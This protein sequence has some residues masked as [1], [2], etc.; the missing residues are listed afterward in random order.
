LLGALASGVPLQSQTTTFT[1]TWYEEV[2]GENI[3]QGAGTLMPGTSFELLVLPVMASR[4]D[5]DA[6]LLVFGT[7]RIS[8]LNEDRWVHKYTY[9]RPGAATSSVG[10]TSYDSRWN[11]PLVW[12]NGVPN[13]NTD[14]Q[15]LGSHI[16]DIPNN[17]APRTSIVLPPSSAGAAS[18]R[19]L[20][21]YAT[22]KDSEGHPLVQEVTL[23]GGT[24][25][26]TPLAF[27][28]SLRVGVASA[29]VGENRT[30]ELTLDGTILTSSGF[31]AIG[32]GLPTGSGGDLKAVM[33]LG[34]NSAWYHHTGLIEV[35]G[36][37][38]TG[39]LLIDSIL[40]GD[41][42]SG[43][44]SNPNLVINPQGKVSTSGTVRLNEVSI[45]SHFPAAD[46]DSAPYPSLTVTEWGTFDTQAFKL[47]DATK[48]AASVLGLASLG[49][50]TV[51]NGSILSLQTANAIVADSL[52]LNS[53]TVGVYAYDVPVNPFII[54]RQ[55]SN[56]GS[57][58]LTIAG[59]KHSAATLQLGG[60]AVLP[61]F[62]D[63]GY[64]GQVIVHGS[65]LLGGYGTAIVEIILASL[66][67]IRG[68]ATVG[69]ISTYRESDANGSGL[70][71]VTGGSKLRAQ[72]IAIGHEQDSFRSI[73][74]TV[75]RIDVGSSG[76]IEVAG[77][78]VSGNAY[79][80]FT[81]TLGPVSYNYGGS[82]TVGRYGLLDLLNGT[83]KVV[84]TDPSA[85]GFLHTPAWLINHGTITGGD[86]TGGAPPAGGQ[87]DFGDR[88]G[89]L[90]NYG[91]IAPG[92]SAGW[93]TIT[94]NLTL[95][96]TS[97]L[98]LELGGTTRGSGYDALTVTGELSAG[99]TLIVS[100][101]NG[102][103]PTSG[104]SFDLFDFGSTSGTFATVNLP[105]GYAWNTDAL[106]TTGVISL[107]AVP[108]PSTYALCAGL[109]ALGIA[110]VRR[111]LR[112]PRCIPLRRCVGPVVR[113][114]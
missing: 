50:I 34:N 31:A 14:A 66:L 5:W 3:Q 27:S 90:S 77:W 16:G 114:I 33:T 52:D 56:P 68:D 104:A 45:N 17:R 38:G 82:L 72:N 87:I 15:I 35:G 44:G 76:R 47:G 83:G 39:R 105:V 73:E 103:S 11:N 12:G 109:G 112:R 80:P 19:S 92:H 24:L 102:F 81:G 48:G 37:T 69:R 91:T 13:A 8:P 10:Y 95:E 6:Q 79:N 107:G 7:P 70:V 40:A 75:G 42:F 78:S 60:A 1:G 55:G 71:T 94:G 65:A 46:T 18:A 32:K 49:A 100:L 4:D 30:T 63:L 74:G 113:S 57:P 36:G 21:I 9:T 61:T 88:G 84:F 99:G 106:Y 110:G 98:L 101:I 93:L 2:N 59:P 58:V 86:S 41:I 64:R 22:E 67:D 51:N 25:N 85:G 26:L 23:S 62:D 28:E 20:K 89:T 97:S 111:R 96:I 43:P 29:V 54:G 108:E 53:G